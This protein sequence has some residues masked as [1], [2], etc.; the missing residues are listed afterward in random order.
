[1][2]N[3]LLIIAMSNLVLSF[4]YIVFAMCFEVKWAKSASK[5]E[6]THALL[7]LLQSSSREKL[8][9]LLMIYEDILDEY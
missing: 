5:S 6:F 8:C 4:Q 9:L 2:F 1:M 3:L 7:L